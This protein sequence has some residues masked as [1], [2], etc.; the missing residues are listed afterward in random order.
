[1]QSNET[2][3]DEIGDIYDAGRRQIKDAYGLVEGWK[4]QL[5]GGF[6]AHM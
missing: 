3:Y 1:M 4:S 5:S 6:A 2:T